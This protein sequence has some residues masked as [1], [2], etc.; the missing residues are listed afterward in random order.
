MQKKSCENVNILGCDDEN[1]QLF[2]FLNESFPY[3]LE[4]LNLLTTTAQHQYHILVQQNLLEEGVTQEDTG[5]G[6]IILD[7]HKIVN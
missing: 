2:S 4:N 7:L 3:K 1:S 6:V 5:P